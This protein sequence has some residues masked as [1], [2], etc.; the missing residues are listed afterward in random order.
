MTTP[1][2]SIIVPTFDRLEALT[3]CVQA[4]KRLDYPRNRFEIII[5]D[6]GSSVPIMAS[7]HHLHDDGTITVLRQLNA[8]PASARN[9]GAQHARGDILAFTDDDCTPT[10]QWL[11]ELAQSFRDVPTGLVGG[12]TVNGLVNNLYSTASQMIVD[13]AYAYFISRNSDLRFFASNNMAVSAKLFHES[14]GFDPSF[15]TSEDR[16]FCDRWIRRE[17]PLVYSPEAIVYHHHH[18]TLMAFF[19]Q[20]FNYGRGAHRFHRARAHRSRSRLKPDLQFY[21]SVCRRSLFSPLSWKSLRMAGLMAVWQAANLA[22]FLWQ[23]FCQ[24]PPP[25]K[26]T[27]GQGLSQATG[28]H[29]AATNRERRED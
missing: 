8:G 18:L 21:A 5:V 14:G 20:H 7:G 10:P 9:K 13:E 4:M 3:A 29:Y 22:G 12:R 27:R 1:F 16:E 24:D 28:T 19:R 17:H 2:F 23:A 15:R 6:D 26:L 25:S 11:R